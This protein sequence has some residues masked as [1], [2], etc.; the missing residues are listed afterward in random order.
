MINKKFYITTAIDYVNSSPHLGTAYEKI[1][2]DVIA[3]YLR[4]QGIDTFFLMGTDEH[5]LNVEK[6]A[7]KQGLAPEV[8]C[9][10]MAEKFKEVW[11][12]LNLSFNDFIRTSETRHINAV[13]DLILKIQKKGDLYKGSYKGW[14]CVSCEAFL[15]EKELNDGKCPT[16][17]KKPQWV[18]EE[19]YF[20]SLSKYENIL[21]DHINKNPQFILPEIRRNEIVNVIKGGLEDISITRASVGWGIPV[22]FDEKQVVYVWFDALINYLSGIGYPDEKYRHYWPCNLH[23]IGKDI[24]RFHCII[25]PA[26]LLSAGI[27]LPETVFGHGFVF[28]GEDKM[29]K[30]LGTVVDPVAIV[31]KY[32]ADSLR[33]FLLREIPFDRD[34]QFTQEKFVGRYQ[35]DLANDLGNL[36]NRV[37]N[38]VHRYNNGVIKKPVKTDDPLDGDIIAIAKK[39]I[40]NYSTYM[41]TYQLNQALTSVWVLVARANR[42]VEETSPWALNKQ[43]QTER[44][45][46]VLYNLTESIRLIAVLIDPFMPETAVKMWQQLGESEELEKLIFSPSIMGELIR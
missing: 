12:K 40:S 46:A 16:H 34:G 31:A 38:M 21:L 7:K 6:Q 29:S 1:G 25:W 26:M 35:S 41:D 19:N 2:A 11:Q 18:E 42:Y 27:D 20:F 43:Q 14:Y 9:D 17:G 10:E 13:Q 32:G 33:Y 37:L 3:R 5:S 39:T 23:V 30:T 36:V 8:Y 44:L 22:P 45:Q 24:T 4:R 28:L 15:K